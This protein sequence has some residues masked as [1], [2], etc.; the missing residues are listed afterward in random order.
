MILNHPLLAPFLHSLEIIIAFWKPLKCDTTTTTNATTKVAHLVLA[1]AVF[2]I[3]TPVLILFIVAGF[4]ASF[5]KS[6][7]ISLHNFEGEVSAS[8][9]TTGRQQQSTTSSSSSS[10]T[11]SRLSSPTIATK[12]KSST[13]ALLAD[14]NTGTTASIPRDVTTDIEGKHGTITVLSANVCLLPDFAARFNQLTNTSERA[15]NIAARIVE[16][17]GNP[18]FSGIGGSRV[19]ATLPSADIVCL[20][21]VFYTAAEHVL[22]QTLQRSYPYMTCSAYASVPGTVK[23]FGSGLFIASKYPITTVVFHAF[24]NSAGE[25]RLACKGMLMAKLD[26]RGSRK[27]SNDVIVVCNTHLQAGTHARVR[28]QQLDQISTW[29]KEFMQTHVYPEEKVLQ[30]ILCG[31]FN[32]DDAELETKDHHVFSS[33]H[34]ACVDSSGRAHQWAIGTCINKTRMHEGALQS[35]DNMCRVLSHTSL[36]HGFVETVTNESGMVLGRRLDRILLDESGDIST[37]HAHI[38]YSSALAT[39]TDHIPVIMV[40][41]RSQ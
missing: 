19:I 15:R 23:M 21:E 25:D 3:Y 37:Q 1:C 32:C 14:H 18:T 34:D 7:N 22:V 26:M 8:G 2:L 33:T 17:N 31:D 27:D 13:E 29:I 12:A 6:N 41:H 4:M 10:S 38:S 5:F 36:R 28:R 35:S 16:E 9:T 20:Q 11:R 40:L 39:L 30:T 24:S